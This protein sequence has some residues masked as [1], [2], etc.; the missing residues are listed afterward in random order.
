MNQEIALNKS[1]IEALYQESLHGL[2]LESHFH[3]FHEIIY[4]TEGSIQFSINGKTYEVNADNI[5]FVSNFESHELK[6]VQY[7]YKR[8]FI[9]IKPDYLQSVIT[10]PAMLSIFKNRPPHFSHKISLSPEHKHTILD[11]ISDIYNEITD[12]KVFWETALKSDLHNLFISLYRDYRDSFPLTTVNKSMNTIFEIQKYIEGHCTEQ[13]TLSQISNLFY[14][15]MYY[16]S[17]LFK[18]VTG[19]TFKQYLLIQRIALAKDRLFHSNEDITQVCINSGFNNVNH[20]IRI[21]KKF[22]G[23]PPYQYRKKYRKMPRH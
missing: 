8:Y 23:I 2:E 22:E 9:L 21:F 19:F 18:N 20:F 1:P 12:K 15:D 10:E 5:I 13:I 4:V 14:I 16:L 7:P 3:N 11:K 6:V 17:H